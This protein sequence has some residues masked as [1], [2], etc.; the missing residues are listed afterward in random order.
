MPLESYYDRRRG[1][2]RRRTW[3]TLL[4]TVSVVAVLMFAGYKAYD[5]GT[6]L[7]Q[8]DVV[9][10]QDSLAELRTINEELR[11][12]N[13]ELAGALAESKM[14]EQKL[15]EKYDRDVPTGPM[16]RLLQ[17]S[18][19][20]VEQG[21][22][23]ERLQF[24][25]A[26]AENRRECAEQPSTKRFLVKTPI[27]QTANDSVS[28]ANNG[29]TITA[30]GE[31][32]TDPLGN[33]EAWFDPAKPVILTFTRLGGKAADRNGLLPLHHSV[34]LNDREYRFSMTAGSRGFVT[35]TGTNCAY[36]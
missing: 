3:T 6:Y 31:S 26:A 32:A 36:P 18:R 7:A 29:I 5:A 27:S 1:Q 13:N 2:R 25:I 30:E 16:K 19:E 9:R 11:G 35:I 15:T 23:P 28:F 22:D 17:L 10:L 24:V 21:V 34:V 8:R 20:K 14:R 4:L 12:E 33:P